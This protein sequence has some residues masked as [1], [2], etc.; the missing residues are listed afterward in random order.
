M[1][2]KKLSG[3]QLLDFVG[4]DEIAPIWI[5]LDVHKK[6]YYVALRR[7]DGVCKSWVSPADPGVLS[8]QFSTISKRISLIVY[9]AGPTGYSLERLLKTNG[10]PVAIIAPSR[11]PRPATK[12]A[13]TDKLDCLKLAE[14]A[15]KGMIEA[16]TTPTEQESAERNVLRR[17]Y[18]LVDS[19]RKTK[20][21]IKS[22][23]LFHGID[24]EV[25][26]RTWNRAAQERLSKLTLH[27]DLK[28]VLKSLLREL[29]YEEAELA[30]IT[31]RLTR[32]TKRKHH[33]E[34]V[35]NLKTVPGVGDIVASAF[36]MELFRPDRF[37]CAEE[38]C[39]YLGLAPAIRQSGEKRR[40]G[41][42]MRSGQARLRS[43]LIEAAWMWRAKDPWARSKYQFHL[44]RCGTAQKSITALARRLAVILWRLSVENRAYVIR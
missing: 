6:S 12:Q 25:I 3:N 15:A 10:Y 14:Y 41:W 8:R 42:L 16:I 26:V 19:T 27:S 31:S 40:S 32:I 37:R 38:V 13:K 30:R 29:K 35:K 23:L 33:F 2:R 44:S 11:I 20:Q 4:T 36:R 34:V 9:E 18:Q 5:G 43:L 7:A 28:F 22:F 17:R 1:T 39:S 24:D 21:R